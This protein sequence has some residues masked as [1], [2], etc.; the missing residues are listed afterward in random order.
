MNP[1][2][3][4]LCP[5]PLVNPVS[6]PRT[7]C[8]FLRAPSADDAIQAALADNPQWRVIGIELVICSHARYGE[9][10]RFLLHTMAALLKS[11]HTGER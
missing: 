5:E 3:V 10:L 4:I 2:C 11:C 7:R 6:Y 9:I 1:Y 8:F